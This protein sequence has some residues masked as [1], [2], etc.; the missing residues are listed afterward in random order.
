MRGETSRDLFNK[1]KQNKSHDGNSHVSVVRLIRYIRLASFTAPVRRSGE[2][3]S[4]VMLWLL[5]FLE[6]YYH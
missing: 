6:D 3:L 2:G 4:K 5:H 1:H